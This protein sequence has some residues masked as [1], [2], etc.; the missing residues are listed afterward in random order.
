MSDREDCRVIGF[1]GCGQQELIGGSALL[2][3]KLNKKIL[4]MDYSSEKEL[5]NIIPS[6][7]SLEG[8]KNVVLSYQSLDYIYAEEV[9]EI[10]DYSF[11]YDI[12]LVDFGRNALH[13][14]RS[15]CSEVYF[16]TDMCRHNKMDLK[17]IHRKENEFLVL[18]HFLS[19]QKEAELIAKELG[20]SLSDVYVLPYDEKEAAQFLCEA[21]I[22][23]LRYGYFAKETKELLE[24]LVRDGDE[25]QVY[26]TAIK[27]LEKGRRA[28]W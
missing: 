15:K 28:L 11:D 13:P 14:E 25:E 12:V 27:S 1:A 17:G 10:S 2:F 23:E 21:R 19:G 8:A 9:V 26:K 18:K 24:N 4:I 5:R 6:P 20:F 7:S 3:S 22:E 16:I